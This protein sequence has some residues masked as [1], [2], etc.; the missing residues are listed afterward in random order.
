MDD[1]E[2]WRAWAR[3][4]LGVES[5]ED[6]TDEKMRGELSELLIKGELDAEEARQLVIERDTAMAH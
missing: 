2:R 3:E 6:W 5:V 4:E 1:L